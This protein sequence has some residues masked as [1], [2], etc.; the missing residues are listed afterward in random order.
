MVVM[1]AFKENLVFVFCFL[2]FWPCESIFGEAVKEVI[3]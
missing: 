2:V 1:A 3:S